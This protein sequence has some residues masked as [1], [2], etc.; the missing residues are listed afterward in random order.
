MGMGMGM[1]PQVVRLLQI[2]FNLTPRPEHFLPILGRGFSYF[3]VSLRNATQ[4]NHAFL[5]SAQRV[6]DISEYPAQWVSC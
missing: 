5:M 2:V 1:G 6:I 4:D 3:V